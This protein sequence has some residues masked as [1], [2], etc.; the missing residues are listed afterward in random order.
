M[1][2]GKIKL[3]GTEYPACLSIR[4]MD[5][6]SEKTGKPFQEGIAELLDSNNYKGMMWVLAEMLEAGKR[7]HDLIGDKT[8][9]PPTMDYLLDALG[10]T[11]FSDL[12]EAI[13]KA[14]VD[15]A[16]ADVE[17]ETDEKN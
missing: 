1:K 17:I 14:A 2:E 15:T 8:P 4:M 16:T 7:H 9:T 11:D 12:S 13:Y 5:K 10:L 3:F 6:I